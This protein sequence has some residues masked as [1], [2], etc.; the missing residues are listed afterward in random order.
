MHHINGEW[1]H[2]LHLCI[3]EE[4]RTLDAMIFNFIS[5]LPPVDSRGN[6]TNKSYQ[7]SVHA[8]AYYSFIKLHESHAQ[9][10]IGAYKRC[11]QAAC[12]ISM[13]LGSFTPEETFEPYSI[14]LVSLKQF[15]SPAILF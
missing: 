10:D 5:T 14:T 15:S 9:V 6:I 13:L 11:V 3:G 2:Y 4:T 12:Y 7:I 1:R 8:I